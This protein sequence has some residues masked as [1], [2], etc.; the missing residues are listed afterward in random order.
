MKPGWDKS[1]ALKRQNQS[2]KEEEDRESELSKRIKKYLEE[3]RIKVVLHMGKLTLSLDDMERMI[4]SLCTTYPKYS[5][6]DLASF[7]AQVVLQSQS[8]CVSYFLAGQHGSVFLLFS[9]GG[10]SLPRF[11]CR[12]GLFKQEEVAAASQSTTGGG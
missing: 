9:S 4:Q 3:N 1:L 2:G 6:R 8:C 7:K 5:R 11:E 10:S 12:S